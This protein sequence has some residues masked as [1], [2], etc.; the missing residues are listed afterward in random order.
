MW[1][2]ALLGWGSPGGPIGA[3]SQRGW[4]WGN[5]MFYFLSTRDAA[6]ARKDGKVTL[7]N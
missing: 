4:V 1:V 3:A 7:T 2:V 5:A 6:E